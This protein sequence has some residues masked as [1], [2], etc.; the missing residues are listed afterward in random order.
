MKAVNRLATRILELAELKDEAT[1]IQTALNLQKETYRPVWNY[2]MRR[3]RFTHYN[4]GTVCHVAAASNLWLLFQLFSNTGANP[5]ELD[6]SNRLP[7]ETAADAGNVCLAVH[8]RCIYET[9]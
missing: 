9:H 6:A 7:S 4:N 3:A 1:A 2:V 8:I 5:N